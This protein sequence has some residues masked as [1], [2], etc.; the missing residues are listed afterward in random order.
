VKAHIR[1]VAPAHCD[2]AQSPD[3]PMVPPKNRF[4]PLVQMVPSSGLM[5]P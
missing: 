1:G 5:F 2:G 3:T 4:P